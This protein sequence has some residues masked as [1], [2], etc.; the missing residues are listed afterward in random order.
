MAPVTLGGRPGRGQERWQWGPGPWGQSVALGH[1]IAKATRQ[2]Q[3]VSRHASVRQVRQRIS[4][5]LQE[6]K[7][8]A[9]LVLDSLEAR[10]E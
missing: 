7:A 1:S 6:A 5:L 10:Q 4:S 8:Q 9:A 2:A 3:V